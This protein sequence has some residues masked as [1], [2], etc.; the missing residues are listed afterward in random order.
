LQGD[1]PVDGGEVGSVGETFIREGEEGENGTEV[2]IS[3]LTH[4]HLFILGNNQK[5][6]ARRRRR[7]QNQ[8]RRINRL[9]R[10]Q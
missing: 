1:R 5:G 6:R 3:S 8:P 4:T 9:D 10:F 7:N 2:N